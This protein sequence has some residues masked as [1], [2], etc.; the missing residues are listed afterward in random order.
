MKK[1]LLLIIT[2]STTGCFI[3]KASEKSAVVGKMSGVN[4]TCRYMVQSQYNCGVDLHECVVNGRPVQK[5][6]CATDVIVN[7]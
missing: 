5:I 7:Y 4:Y 2:L 1:I 3:S 6:V